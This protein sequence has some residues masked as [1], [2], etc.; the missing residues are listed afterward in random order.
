MPGWVFD[1]A[2]PHSA[3][4]GIVTR[5]SPNGAD[6]ASVIETVP[7]DDMPVGPHDDLRYKHNFRC[8]NATNPPQRLS[9]RLPPNVKKVAVWQSEALSDADHSGWFNRQPD[10][11]TVDGVV[12]IEV[13][14]Q[15]V[16]TITSLMNRGHKG[17]HPKPPSPSIPTAFCGEFLAPRRQACLCAKIL[18]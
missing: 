12:D 8:P 1:R 18:P 13:G 4:G 17:S 9:F 16:I 11:Q 15:K 3:E 5:H 7:C 10:L 14:P 2:N 6:F